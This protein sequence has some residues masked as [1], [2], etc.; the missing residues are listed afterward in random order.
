[1]FGPHVCYLVLIDVLHIP[2]VPIICTYANNLTCHPYKYKSKVHSV[3]NRVLLVPN[4][5]PLHFV[6]KVKPAL[7]VKII[8]LHH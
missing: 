4:V 7:L 3:L 5:I 8:S 6:Q 2:P 1:M